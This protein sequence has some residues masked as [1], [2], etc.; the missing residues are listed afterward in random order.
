LPKKTQF[1]FTES[2]QNFI[3]IFIIPLLWSEGKN[4]F[5]QRQTLS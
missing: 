1:S 3:L 2:L 4:C 5:K